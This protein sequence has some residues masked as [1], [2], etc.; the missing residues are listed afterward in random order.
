MNSRRNFILKGSIATT[1]LL[2]ARPLKAIA[3]AASS[4]SGFS[5]NN[6]QVVFLHTA[7]LNEGS[8]NR[9]MRF[10]EMIKDNSPNTILLNAGNKRSASL[11]FDVSIQP[12]ETSPAY[13]IEYSIVEKEGIRTGVIKALPGDTDVLLKKEKDCQVVVCLSQLGYKNNSTPDDESLAAS[14]L[15]IDLIVSGHMTNFYPRPVVLA[16]K[17]KQEVIIH[18]SAGTAHACGKVEIGL[19]KYGVKSKVVL[20]NKLDSGIFE[21]KKVVKAS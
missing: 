15:H 19:D 12:C 16:N 11:P 5:S 14:S 13:N 9:A 8:T 7:E 18:A 21:N 10:I 4:L 17:Q 2:A 3:N 6:N 20:A 1:A